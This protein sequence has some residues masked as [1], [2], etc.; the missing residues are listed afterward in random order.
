MCRIIANSRDV[1]QLFLERALCNKSLEE[2]YWIYM[3]LTKAHVIPYFSAKAVWGV[4]GGG[5][6]VY[7]CPSVRIFYETLLGYS[8][9]SQIVSKRN[10]IQSCDQ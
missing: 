4:G 2:T 1:T 9:V 7:R 3:L 5:G 6:F 10:P 8:T